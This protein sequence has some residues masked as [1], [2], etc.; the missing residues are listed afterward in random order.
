MLKLRLNKSLV[1]V[2]LFSLLLNAMVATVFTFDGVAEAAESK[3]EATIIINGTQQSFSQPAV[4]IK[5]VTMVPMRAIFEKLGATILFNQQSKEVTATKGSTTIKITIDSKIAYVNGKIQTLTTKAQ[6]LNNVTIVPLRFVSEALGANVGWDASTLTVNISDQSISDPSSAKSTESSYTDRTGRVVTKGIDLNIAY[7]N[8][9][10]V[11][12]SFT[13]QL[14]SFEGNV[15]N[16]VEVSGR[17]FNKDM[18][19]YEVKFPVK[20]YRLGDKF[21][22]YLLKAETNIHSLVILRNTFIDEDYLSSQTEL[23]V[24]NFFPLTIVAVDYEIDE[25]GT[26]GL[27]LDPSE[28]LPIDGYLKIN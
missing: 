12:P 24:G 11:I 10:L 1:L 22:I 7:N 3:V 21:Q 25:K 13:L 8:N 18:Q 4:V 9:G 14:R 23:K 28:H 19:Q 17:N 6:T 5:G 2:L 16:T 20:E 26:L 27:E 15:I